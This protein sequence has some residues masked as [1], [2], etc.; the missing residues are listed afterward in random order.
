MRSVSRFAAVL[1]VLVL[2]PALFAGLRDDLYIPSTF[3]GLTHYGAFEKHVPVAVGK[4]I[5]RRSVSDKRALGSGP[6]GAYGLFSQDPPD[7]YIRAALEQSLKSLGLEPNEGE[8][9]EL[10][11]DAEIWRAHAWV[12]VGAR[13]RLRCEINVRFLVNGN[14]VSVIGNSEIKGQVVTKARWVSLFNDA[15][16]DTMEK[17]AASQTFTK[18]L[19]SEVTASFKKSTAPAPSRYNAGDIET[20]KFYGPTDL[21]KQ[22]PKVDLTSYDVLEIR[23]FTLADKNFKGDV[24][25][26]QRMVPGSVMDRLG[27]RYPGLFRAVSFG[28]AKLGEAPSG[29]KRLVIEGDLPQVAAG[30]FMK[31]AII[32][33]GAGRV[34]F[35]MNV[36]LVDGESGKPL[37][38]LEMKSLNWGAA[39]QSDEGELED[40]VDRMAADLA[41]Y[42]VNQHN[43]SYKSGE[44]EAR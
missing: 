39:W 21:V 43:P 5:D 2:A 32:G 4:V 26:A 11:V 10:T 22:L 3:N 24:A 8:T 18:A 7:A 16:S 27:G 9:P 25:T 19:P 29:A 14:T 6:N 40:M 30:S 1:C 35:A 33:F 31:R 12:R 23:E 41:Y 17:F 37:T 36:R 42:L 13:A 38:T 34:S 44:E 20:A 28:E 15:L